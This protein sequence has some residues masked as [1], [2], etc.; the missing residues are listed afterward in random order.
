MTIYD[1]IYEMVWETASRG[2]GVVSSLPGD[3][4]AQLAVGICSREMGST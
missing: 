2:I 4:E 1:H 3:K